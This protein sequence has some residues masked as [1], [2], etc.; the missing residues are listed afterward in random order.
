MG[1]L[2]NNVQLPEQGKRLGQN[3]CYGNTY[4][5]FP[6]SSYLCITRSPLGA[7]TTPVQA[8]VLYTINLMH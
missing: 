4:D 6:A 2:E 7:D 5:Y 8:I 3:L 1:A